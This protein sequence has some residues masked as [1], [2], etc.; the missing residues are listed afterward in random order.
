M[1]RP[2]ISKKM[3]AVNDE[4][5]ESDLELWTKKEKCRM[6]RT[7]ALRKSQSPREAIWTCNRQS[8][9]R[10]Q[11]SDS[12]LGMAQNCQPTER[13]Y[14]S[15]PTLPVKRNEPPVGVIPEVPKQK[16]GRPLGSKN[17]PEKV[18]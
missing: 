14:T 3:K 9:G 8:E 12:V 5:R 18:D 4:L 1:A 17:K 2:T 11:Y 16:Q 10:L 13:L 15:D 7:E 6:I